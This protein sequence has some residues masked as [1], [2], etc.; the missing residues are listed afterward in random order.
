MK[1]PGSHLL[2]MTGLNPFQQDRLKIPVGFNIM[3]TSQIYLTIVQRDDSEYRAA[4]TGDGAGLV[5]S[6]RLDFYGVGARLEAEARF[7]LFPVCFDDG[8]AG[9]ELHEIIL[10]QS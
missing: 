3:R 2:C 1:T 10:I 7:N 5:A 9:S 8:A 4:G 6:G